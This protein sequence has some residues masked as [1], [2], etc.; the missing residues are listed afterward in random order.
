[1]TH[2]KD[3]AAE[4]RREKYG[5]PP[6]PVRIEDTVISQETQPARDSKG[7]RGDTDWG[8]TSGIAY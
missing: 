8:F 2:E 6:P 1:M 7:E 5:H 3:A 4:A